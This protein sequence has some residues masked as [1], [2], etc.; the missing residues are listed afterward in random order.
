MEGEGEMKGEGGM[1]D[2]Q[3]HAV[4]TIVPPL[5]SILLNSLGLKT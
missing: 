4:K 2:R 3:Q 5:Y 1:G